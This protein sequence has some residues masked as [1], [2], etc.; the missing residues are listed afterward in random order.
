M[1][2]LEA[3][4]S[5]DLAKLME[6]IKEL[7]GKGFGDGDEGS[8]SGDKEATDPKNETTPGRDKYVTTTSFQIFKWPQPKMYIILQTIMS[9]LSM[10]PLTY[11]DL[12]CSVR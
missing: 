5:S 3:K 8:G 10:P 6:T 7:F 4:I 12:L 9:Q 1:E 11:C 2:K